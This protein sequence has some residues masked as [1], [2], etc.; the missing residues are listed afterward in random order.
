MF[1]ML[2]FQTPP[3]INIVFH[4]SV[5]LLS[6]IAFLIG[7]GLWY[8]RNI[9]HLG[10]SHYWRI[11]ITGVLFYAIAEFAD[12][13]TPGLHASLGVHN[14]ITEMTLLVGLS[15]IFV[16]LYRFLQDYIGEKH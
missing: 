16:A 10:V 12:I 11:F 6:L 2:E 13:F 8:N 5:F 9:N 15:L 3:T 14:L 7:I 4:V 1:T